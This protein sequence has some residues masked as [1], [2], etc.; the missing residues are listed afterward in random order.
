[1]RIC[2]LYRDQDEDRYDAAAIKWLTRFVAEAKDVSLEDIQSA[3]GA[4]DA[5]PEQP[6][7][8][9]EQL[10]ALCVRYGLTH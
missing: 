8:A 4:L 5:L 2:L 3:A 10:S 9:M 1:M 7:T 6:G